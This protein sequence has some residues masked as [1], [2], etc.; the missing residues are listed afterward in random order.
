MVI[1]GLNTTSLT[2]F[3]SNL[4]KGFQYVD[5]SSSKRGLFSFLRTSP[6]CLIFFFFFYDELLVTVGHLRCL[7]NGLLKYRI[8]V[9][10]DL[11]SGTVV[12]ET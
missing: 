11:Y 1:V 10:N 8:V 7:P 2:L 5:D 3:L 9:V 12:G 6:L 4:C